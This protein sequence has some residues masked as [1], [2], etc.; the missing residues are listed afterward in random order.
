MKGFFKLISTKNSS[1]EKI[2]LNDK[3]RISVQ[4]R[5]CF[6][7]SS[8]FNFQNVI[9]VR[10]LLVTLICSALSMQ[11]ALQPLEFHL[12]RVAVAARNLIFKLG[13]LGTGTCPGSE[14]L[15]PH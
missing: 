14:K 1:N 5:N 2:S 11:M 13:L 6:N 10:T 7:A 9:L 15:S 4:E 8:A 3:I 12:R